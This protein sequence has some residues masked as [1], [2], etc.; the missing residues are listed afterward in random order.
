MKKFIILVFA[1]TLLL[2]NCSVK[3]NRL[4]ILELKRPKIELKKD[5]LDQAELYLK[6]IKYYKTDT[7]KSISVILIGNKISTEARDIIEN[8]RNVE[9]KTYQDFLAKT[10]KRYTKFLEATEKNET[11]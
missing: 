8:R 6:I 2:S 4:I 7:Y 9:I 11:K 3:E 10:K 1:I 5:E